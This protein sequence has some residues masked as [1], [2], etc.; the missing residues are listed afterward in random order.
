MIEEF[1]KFLRLELPRVVPW[2]SGMARD[3]KNMWLLLLF[4]MN[5]LFLLVY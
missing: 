3:P 1:V 2:P 4:K 5:C